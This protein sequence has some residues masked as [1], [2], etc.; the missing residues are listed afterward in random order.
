MGY[1]PRRV[2]VAD[3]DL[4]VRAALLEALEAEG[5]EAR[6]VANGAE[7]LLVLGHW[8]ADLIVLDLL[9]PG[10]DGRAVLTERGRV[11]GFAETPVLLISAAPDLT[12][13]TRGLPA[14]AVYEKPFPLDELLA[15]VRALTAPVIRR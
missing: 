13:A 5:Y 3:D 7:A 6:G 2:L 12:G 15:A 9:M 1:R 14:V 11:A 4:D 10:I 8:R